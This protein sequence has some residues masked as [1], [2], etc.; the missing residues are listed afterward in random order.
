[1]LRR[2]ATSWAKHV[3]E[4]MPFLGEQRCSWLHSMYAWLCWEQ[5]LCTANRHA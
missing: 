4:H 3:A 1:M 2:T 5:R